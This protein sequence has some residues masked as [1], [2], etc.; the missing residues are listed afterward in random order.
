MD[1]LNDPEIASVFSTTSRAEVSIGGTVDIGGEARTISGKIDRLAVIDTHVLIVDY[2]TN[3][4]A[5]AKLK[6][7]PESHVAQLAL[8]RAILAPL[9]PTR[10]I[11]AAL[12]YTEGPHFIKIDG[13]RL[14]GALEAITAS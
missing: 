13:K 14:D 9:Y 6:D 11:E 5:P 4:P 2:K 10:T 12:I 1:I 3:R 8:Y 7:V